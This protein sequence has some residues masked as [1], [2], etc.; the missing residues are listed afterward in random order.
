MS[1]EKDFNEDAM[2]D[3]ILNAETSLYM[4]EMAKID[5]E[6]GEESELI[7]RFFARLKDRTDY[8]SIVMT[9][10]HWKMLDDF[11]QAKLAI[12]FVGEDDASRFIILMDF[13]AER[14]FKG[15]L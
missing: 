4:Q 5:E 3:R 14:F 13:L 1:R 15:E 8:K 2:W 11:K 12:E 9:A 7:K 6:L 10:M